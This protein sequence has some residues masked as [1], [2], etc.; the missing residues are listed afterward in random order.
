M[1]MPAM[2]LLE[3]ARLGVRRAQADDAEFIHGLWTSPDVMRFVGFPNGLAIS[4][5]QIRDQ[6]RCGP[7]TEFGALLIAQH[8]VLGARIGQCKIG[9]PD[10]DG[11]CEPDIKLHPKHWGNGYGRELWQ[12]LIDYAL[13]HPGIAVVQGTPHRDNVASVRMQMGAGMTQVDEGIFTEHVRLVSG[14]IPVPYLK[15]QITRNQWAARK[16]GLWNYLERGNG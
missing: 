13:E 11:L 9:V 14:A 10:R 7:D 8:L 5:E 2:L 3:T 4:I 6:I 15:L 12:A 16:A 1:L